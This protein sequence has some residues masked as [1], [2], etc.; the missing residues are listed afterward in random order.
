MN[1]TTKF[2]QSRESQITQLISVLKDPTN[3]PS[4]FTVTGNESTG[5][6][7][8]LHYLLSR[9][10]CSDAT[11]L[12]S[13][14][15][16][17]VDCM[18]H[19]STKSLLLDIM[20]QFLEQFPNNTRIVKKWSSFTEFV[21]VLR[22]VNIDPPIYIVVDN[23]DRLGD[24]GFFDAQLVFNLIHLSHWTGKK[25]TP[26][27]VSRHPFSTYTK[28]CFPEPTDIFFAPYTKEEVKAIIKD[29]HVLPSADKTLFTYLSNLMVDVCWSRC[30]DLRELIRIT[31][32]LY[33]ICEQQ[34]NNHEIFKESF[35]AVY[36]KIKPNIQKSVINIYRRDK[37]T[38]SPA[39]VDIIT[40]SSVKKD[41]L[42]YCTKYILL[43]CYLASVIPASHDTYVFTPN[44]K[45]CDLPK[46]VE[47][48][49]AS[50]VFTQQRM[51]NIFS[52]IIK[53]KKTSFV[54]PVN[55][56]FE[57]ASLVAQN[58]LTPC[59]GSDGISKFQMNTYDS[60]FIQKLAHSTGFGTELNNY[61]SMY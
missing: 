16:S 7:A 33:P 37:D 51:T 24:T 46:R 34:G 3:L 28:G 58:F 61:L 20:E 44:G 25:V 60:S 6:T 53:G 36:A 39:N 48:T 1:W 5:K 21:N 9:L 14:Y 47:G 15:Y 55:I 41:D 29:H 31:H 19:F 27:F 52:K 4:S 30:V 56:R 10:Q 23:A 12:P 35:M 18:Y 26:I 45:K 50:R 2:S 42:P 43:A 8:I 13:F 11:T 22:D 38:T 49:N 17:F 40:S 57:I 59:G 54:G 32:H